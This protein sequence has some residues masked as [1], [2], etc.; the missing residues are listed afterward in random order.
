MVDL[1]RRFHFHVETKV[2]F[3]SILFSYV[4]EK[5][6][7]KFIRFFYIVRKKIGFIGQ[8]S[9]PQLLVPIHSI[10]QFPSV[11]IEV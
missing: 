3:I 7:S 5:A 10:G 9:S 1:A 8:S 4:F 6:C 11:P 2:G